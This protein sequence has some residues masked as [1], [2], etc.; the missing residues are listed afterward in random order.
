MSNIE[1]YCDELIYYAMEICGNIYGDNDIK[2]SAV[3]IPKRG[4]GLDSKG[5]MQ[6]GKNYN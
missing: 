2:D 6:I 4:I 5:A 3:S 1:E